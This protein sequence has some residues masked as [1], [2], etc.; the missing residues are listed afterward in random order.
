M[1]GKRRP[2]KPLTPGHIEDQAQTFF[3]ALERNGLLPRGVSA[4]GAAAAVFCTLTRRVGAGEAREF[5]ESM[6]PMLRRLLFRC[7]R[8][9]A[10]PAETFG[11]QEFVGRVAAHFGIST[12]D[13]E[14]VANAVFSAMRACLPQSEVDD[15]ASQLP[16]DLRELWR[17]EPP[18]GTRRIA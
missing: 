10:E 14:R 12:S 9:R 13:A 15:V 16:P 4:D 3:A 1:P 11:R 8:H 18:A 7:R 5:A 17:P 6:P 2:E